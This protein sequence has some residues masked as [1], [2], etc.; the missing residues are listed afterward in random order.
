MT[1]RR[2]RLPALVVV[3][4]LAALAGYFQFSGSPPQSAPESSRYGL[5]ALDPEMPLRSAE[6]IQPLPELPPLDPQ[7]VAL[8]RQ[9][10]HDRRL[11]ADNSISCASC[12]D[13]SRGGVDGRP[14][15]QG[16]GGARGDVNAPSVLTASLNFRQFWDGRA[17]TLEEQAGGPIL[18]PKEMAAAW[19]EVIERLEADAG[20]KRAFMGVYPDGVTPDNVVAAIADFERSLPRPSRFDRWLRGDRDALSD[21]ER[22]GYQLFKKHGCIGCHQGANV[23]GNLFQRFGIMSHYFNTKNSIT[24]ADRGRYNVTGQEEDRYIFKVPS[25]RNVALTAP[26]F[27]DGS[28]P[29]LEDAVAVMGRYQLGINLPARD[30]GLIAAFLQSLTSETLP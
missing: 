2:A 27:H 3:L 10:F 6:P 9:L 24:Q 5:P 8:G 20:M 30:I 17:A 15:S 22:Q 29:R 1:F 28:V 14:V 16:V 13:L 12:H 25:L 21:E 18:N 23:G 19:P 26:Y 11:S 7:K 4:M